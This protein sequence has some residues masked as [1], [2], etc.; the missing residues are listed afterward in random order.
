MLIEWDESG[1]SYRVQVCYFNLGRE[2][3]IQDHESIGPLG[4]PVEDVDPMGKLILLA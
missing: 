4:I 1:I 2:L 3:T